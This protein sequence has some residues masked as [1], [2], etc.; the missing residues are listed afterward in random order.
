MGFRL[1]YFKKRLP[2]LSQYINYNALIYSILTIM[3]NC[4]QI[5]GKP[6]LLNF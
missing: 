6:N 3:K 2:I 1:I 4:F 5:P